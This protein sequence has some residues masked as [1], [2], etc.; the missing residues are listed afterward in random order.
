ML[1]VQLTNL[2]AI[3]DHAGVAPNVSSQAKHWSKTIEQAVWEYTV[4]RVW[5][6]V[7]ISLIRSS[8]VVDGIFAYE[9]NGMSST[10][11]FA[12]LM[13][14]SARIGFALCDGRCKRPG[15][16]QIPLS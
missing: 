15:R 12:L 13:R 6:K 2:A 16:C 4:R 7:C 8:Q 10:A 14:D 3:L 9:T 1:S 11:V 5:Q